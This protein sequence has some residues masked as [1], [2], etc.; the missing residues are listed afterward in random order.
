MGS[1]RICH[2]FQ[3]LKEK[4]LNSWIDTQGNGQTTGPRVSLAYCVKC[5]AT[6]EVMSG[7]M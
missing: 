4:H 1:Y 3:D 5:T 6:I 7:K 2:V